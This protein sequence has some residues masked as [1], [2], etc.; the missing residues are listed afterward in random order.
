MVS[1][2]GMPHYMRAAKFFIISL[3]LFIGTTTFSVISGAK[4][5]VPA[6][7]NSQ[8]KQDLKRISTYL[9]NLGTIKGGF[10]QVASNGGTSSG[11]IFISRP[12]KMRIEYDPPSPILIIANGTFLIFIDKDLEQVDRYLLK[13]TP[14]NFLLQED[15]QMEGNITVSSFERARGF[16]RITVQETNEPERGSLTLT[17]ADKPLMLRKWTVLDSQQ[18]RTNVMLTGI[19]SGMELDTKLFEYN[20]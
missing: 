13:F 6:R 3:C 12:G 5:A 20:Q 4:T 15:I 16:L 8:D 7:L 19:E 14:V 9:K 17:F 1:Y 10:I 11:K 2:Q 18:I